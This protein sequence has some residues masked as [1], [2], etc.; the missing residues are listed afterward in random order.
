MPKTFK[1]SSVRKLDM[2]I[3]D[4]NDEQTSSAKKRV[5]ILTLLKE[6]VRVRE[7]LLHQRCNIKFSEAAPPDRDY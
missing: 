7:K 2:V 4:I 3:S 1:S 5:K 6:Q